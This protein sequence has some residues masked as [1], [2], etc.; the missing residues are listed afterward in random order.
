MTIIRG[1]YNATYN[2]LSIGNTQVGYRHSYSYQ[3]RPINFDAVGNTPVDT[4][5]AGI[6]MSVD[7]VAQ[8]YDAAA[9]DTLR[10][11][12]NAAIGRVAPAGLSMWQLAKPL[13]LTSCIN[14]INPQT[15]TFIKAILA[16]DFDLD[17]EYS[18]KERPLPMRL[19]VFPVKYEADGD[20]SVPE[21]PTGCNDLVYFTE[22]DWVDPSA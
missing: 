13:I 18:H 12:F 2:A 1:S 20:Y 15:L 3:G 21:M 14:G 10:W 22:E 19:T 11:P 8:E 16:P 6:S 9:I 17:I 7:F 4:I 5:F